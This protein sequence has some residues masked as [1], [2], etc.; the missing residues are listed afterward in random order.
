MD[1]AIVSA[2]SGLAG[3]AIGGATS[4]WSSLLSQVTID[5]RKFRE[6]FWDRRSK[7]YTDFIGVAAS[8]FADALTHQREDPTD[9][10]Q[11]YA[12][13][14]RMR[15]V[16]PRPVIEAAEAVT[17]SLQEI[18]EA[19]TRPLRKFHLFSNDPWTDPLL[20]FS[21]AARRDLDS[22]KDRLLRPEKLASIRRAKPKC[23]GKPRG[24]D[25]ASRALP[26]ADSRKKVEL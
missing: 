21:E 14:A 26:R 1:V 20:E 12:L 16:S 4:A 24:N 8:H 2:L 15:L 9:L 25:A 22:S 3:A 23:D 7:L 10:V 19:P 11:L 13:V 18:Y 6:L 17:V 5:R